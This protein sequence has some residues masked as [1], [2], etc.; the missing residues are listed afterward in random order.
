MNV[1][2]HT[3]SK[4][5]SFTGTGLHSGMYIRARIL[6]ADPDT[7]I[8]ITSYSIHYTKLYEFHRGDFRTTD[9]K[10]CRIGRCDYVLHPRG[11]F[12]VCVV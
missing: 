2:Q 11:N 4:P 12:G 3:V 9:G 6:P 1:F 10:H 7:G 8:V 5:L